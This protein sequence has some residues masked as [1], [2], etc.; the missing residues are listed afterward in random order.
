MAFYFQFLN[1]SICCSP[2]DTLLNVFLA[3]AVDNLANAQELTKDEEEMEEATNQKLALQKAKEVA[4]VSPMS[5][6]N[7][8][9]AAKQQ[10]SSKSKSVWEQRTSQIRMHNF[11]ASC[12]ALYNELDPEERVRYA[13]T[14]HIRPDMKT[15]LDRPLVVEPRSEG[16]NNISKLSPV[17]VQEVEQTKVSSTDGAEAPR[18][19]HRHRDK[20]KLGEQEKGDVTKDENGETGT[21]NKEE[22]H[23]QHRSR[24][25]EVEGGSKE[26]KSDRNRTQE[27]GKRHHRRG[28]V[29][30]GAEKEHRRHRTHRHSAERQGK[31][32]NGT[33]N[34]ARSERRSRHRGGSRSGN[35]E[36]EP[37][38]KG[39]NGEEPHRRHR[40]RNKALSTYDSVEKENGEKEGEAGEKEHRNHQ[41][42]ENQC[43][44]EASGS[45]SVPVHTLPS[46]Y[47]Q[48]VL[49]Q[50]EDADN[51]KNVTRMIQPPL[52][53]TT[54]V[55]IPVTI[56]A[57]PGE[58]TV[59][60]MNN[61]EFESKTEE[62]KDVDDLTKNGPKPILPYSSMFILS[63]TNPIRRLFHYIVNLRYFEMVILIVIALSSIALAAE[64]P[65]QAESPRNDALKYLDYIFTGVFTFEMVIKMI[66]LGLL[67]HPGS[68]FRDLWNILDFI[69]VSG[70]LVAFAFSGT[71]G[72]DINTIKSLRVLRVLRPLKTIKRLPKLK[73]V[74][75]CVVNSLK[76]VLNILIVYMLFM[77]IFAV[78]AVQLFKGRF[79]Y[80]T[81]ESKELEKDC[82]VLKHSVD[83]TYEEQG[84]SPGYRMEMSIFYVV[85]FVVFPFFFVN[86]FVALIIITFQEQ[87]DKVMSECS[88]EK[89]E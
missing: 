20:D 51:Q 18:K 88:L 84:P 25:K 30:E 59:I 16:R 9:I 83:A 38:S 4:E 80:C 49:E 39:E 57:P 7:I 67:L 82:S 22:R 54:T 65:V 60:P 56:T 12:E 10:N 3:I 40:F 52:D 53:K 32:G 68:Y 43:E 19:H 78:I 31:E 2:K 6:A 36:G 74:F 17:D 77:F 47:L 45:M 71:K 66:D 27:G 64:D 44:I 75:D 55:N 87:G 62:K 42:K 21:N 58:T 37:G 50:P 15:H 89:N 85:Y 29:E 26:G 35:R 70:A 34:G 1:I 5:A 61:V 48:K 46:T 73:A 69:V 72:K 86:I 11:R 13:T 33:V 14:L 76:N 79:F 8:S 41:P 24:S 28:S 23:R 63:P 81:D